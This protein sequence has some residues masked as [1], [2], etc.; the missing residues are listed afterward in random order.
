MSV[1]KVLTGK[2]YDLDLLT[3]YDNYLRSK[4]GRGFIT[5]VDKF[6]R[7]RYLSQDRAKAI[8]DKISELEEE[9]KYIEKR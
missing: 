6:I 1:K 7:E 5:H 4:L 9:L 2:E 3:Q 8:R